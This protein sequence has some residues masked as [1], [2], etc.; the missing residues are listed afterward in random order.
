M[1][2]TGSDQSLIHVESL[3]DEES[4]RLL[5]SKLNTEFGEEQYAELAAAVHNVP[6]AL[7]QAAAF[8]MEE[9][10]SISEYLH[11]CNHSDES[12]FQLLGD[13][14]EDDL[15][16]KDIQNA[17]A[18][19]LIISYKEIKKSDPY[20]AEILSYMC[21]LDPQAIPRSLLPGDVNSVMFQKALGTL[22][23]FS[24]INKSS[25]QAQEDE[26][27]DLHQLVRLVMLG[28]LGEQKELHMSMKT[29]TLRVLRR[30]PLG[31]DSS[32][33]FELCRTY[34]PHAWAL[35]STFRVLHKSVTSQMMETPN[36]IQMEIESDLLFMMADYSSFLHQFNIGQQFLQRCLMIRKRVLGPGHE[37][38]LE[39][40][41]FL[42]WVFSQQQNT[43]EAT[44][45]CRTTLR[46]AE[47]SL[48]RH[49][50]TTLIMMRQLGQSLSEQGMHKEAGKILQRTWQRT[51][52]KYGEGDV[53]TV[54]AMQTFAHNLD[55]QGKHE[56]AEQI[57]RKSLQKI[58]EEFPAN[59]WCMMN[60]TI[61][62]R[63][64]NRFEEAEKIFRSILQVQM[65]NMGKE[66]PEILVTM[67]QI[68]LYLTAQNKH[69]EAEEMAR[70]MLRLQQKV[71][72]PDTLQT[73]SDSVVDSGERNKNEQ[74]AKMARPA[75]QFYEEVL[76]ANHFGFIRT[77][78]IIVKT[79]N[80]Q[81][82]HAEAEILE[83][84][85]QERETR[86]DKSRPRPPRNSKPVEGGLLSRFFRSKAK[87]LDLQP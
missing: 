37:K 45:I 29:A 47:K 4:V 32:A 19:T 34:S 39:C 60:L 81:G 10:S 73:V 21:M 50:E 35:I 17:V 43:I 70:Q 33:I 16:D 63:R 67:L 51:Q 36:E 74:A 48:G 85:L 42:V 61:C 57:M 72:G 31:W 78:R 22:Q 76:G 86:A 49:H 3:T 12:K 84:Y 82:N 2:F 15:R 46:Q 27:Y 40:A 83:L 41:G 7:V 56:E 30:F 65:I 26:F 44:Q 11:L 55:N 80:K 53:L 52:K 28:Y 18:R 23:A 75:L 62:L 38:T 87:D 5:Q 54:A 25:R 13:D 24:L 79:L 71:F 58:P 66:H 9:S 14:F 68:L 8:I 1:K 6:L 64:Q 69:E 59:L 77:M 20:A